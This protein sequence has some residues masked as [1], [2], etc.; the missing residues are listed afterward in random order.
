[1][2]LIHHG[3]AAVVLVGCSWLG[4]A[5]ADPDPESAGLNGLDGDHAP[6]GAIDTAAGAADT[7]AHTVA[8]GRADRE[9]LPAPPQSAAP[10]PART[11]TA[12]VVHGLVE[13]RIDSEQFVPADY[14]RA[15]LRGGRRTPEALTSATGEFF[16]ENV[17]AGTYELAFLTVTKDARQVYATKVEVGSGDRVLLPHVHIPIDSVR[18]RRY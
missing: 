14:L 1:M 13:L 2:R 6:P 3:A 8:P 7:A 10:P 17:P 5:C 15:V 12:R 11:A 9:P 4:A 18:S 16:F